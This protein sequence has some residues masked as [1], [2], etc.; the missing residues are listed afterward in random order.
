MWMEE[1]PKQRV[2]TA[3]AKEALETGAKTVAV[4][5]PFCLTMMT[6]GVAAQSGEAQVLDLAE[7]LVSSLK[8]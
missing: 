8:L 4:G 6:D 1:D 2:S 7:V 3:R 5:C